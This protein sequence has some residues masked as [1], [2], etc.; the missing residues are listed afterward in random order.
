MELNHPPKYVCKYIKIR[1]LWL[2]ADY[3]P[4]ARQGVLNK[5]P[6]VWLDGAKPPSNTFAS[7]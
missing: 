2:Y 6:T 3:F 4:A 1:K 5:D 7:I